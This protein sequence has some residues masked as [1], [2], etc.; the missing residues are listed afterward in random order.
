MTVGNE[1]RRESKIFLLSKAKNILHIGCGSYPITAMVLA[2]IDAVKIVAIDNDARVVKR[3]SKIINKYNLNGKVKVEKG[4][5]IKYPLDEFDT[6]II[7]GCSVPKIKVIEHVLK[8]AKPQ[9]RIVLRDSFINIKSIIE[10]LNPDYDIKLVNK[11]ENHLFPISGWESY[12]L[13]KN[14]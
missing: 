8:D 13:I 4:N 7:S 9:S 3:A 14:N 5:G 11:I 6:I 12:Y 10:D 2:E 1:Y